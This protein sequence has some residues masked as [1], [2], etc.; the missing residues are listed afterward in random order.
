MVLLTKTMCLSQMKS[1]LLIFV[2]S[3]MSFNCFSQSGNSDVWAL[4]SENNKVEVYSKIVSC[5]IQGAPN[6]FEYIMFKVV[7]NNSDSQKIGLQFEIYFEEG[8]NGCQGKDETYTEIELNSG[9]SVEG[10]CSNM[11]NKLA[12]FILNPSFDESWHYSHSKV[13]I[14]EIK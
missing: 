11:E 3:I 13:L 5:D 9:E 8:C 7:N 1:N 4:L 14:N 10:S 12:Y 6:S 2:L